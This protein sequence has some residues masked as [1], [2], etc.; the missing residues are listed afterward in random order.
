MA[1]AKESALRGAKTTILSR[2]V[3]AEEPVA[4]ALLGA[5]GVA[6]TYVR[7]INRAEWPRWQV[8]WLA[9]WD[10]RKAQ[11]AAQAVGARG[12][13]MCRGA[14]GVRVDAS[15]VSAARGKLG[16]AGYSMGEDLF[17]RVKG[18]PAGTTPEELEGELAAAGWATKVLTSGEGMVVQAERAA[19][20]TTFTVKGKI[21]EVGRTVRPLPRGVFATIPPGIGYS[22][23]LTA[24][25]ERDPS[26]HDPGM[27]ALLHSKVEFLQESW[28]KEL[29][30]ERGERERQH[31]ALALGVQK[32]AEERRKGDEILRSQVTESHSRLER[33]F[34]EVDCALKTA[35]GDMEGRLTASQGAVMGQMEGRLAGHQEAAMSRMNK[36]HEAGISV[37]LAKITSMLKRGKGTPIAKRK[38]RERSEP[39]EY[40]AEEGDTPTGTPRSN[41]ARRLFPGPP[42][43]G[44]SPA[45]MNFDTCP[46]YESPGPTS[47]P[48]KSQQTPKRSKVGGDG[49]APGTPLD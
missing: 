33:R 14:Y 20:P 40:S 49:S 2:V 29:Q 30:M 24:A 39:V 34:S 19:P 25:A 3:T 48:Q 28:R 45:P 8:I 38:F 32:E 9:G 23:A 31:R 17:Y 35:L 16:A 36:Q 42:V 1:G 15:E 5:S 6:N 46:R 18:I 26:R 41:P 11:E 47:R 27:V 37:L 4:L 43:S 44:S 7:P 10:A 12:V 13:A 21:V 22:E